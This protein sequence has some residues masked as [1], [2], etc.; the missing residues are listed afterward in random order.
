VS[1]G[2]S[3]DGGADSGESELKDSRCHE[4]A[5]GRARALVGQEKRGSVEENSRQTASGEGRKGSVECY[6][7]PSPAAL[8]SLF[9]SD[10][11]ST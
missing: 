11:D 2:L 7:R 3:A 10:E 4:E 1:A 5:C 6:T 9:P 8:A